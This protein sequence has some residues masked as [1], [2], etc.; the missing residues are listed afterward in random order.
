MYAACSEGLLAHSSAVVSQTEE[1][2]APTLRQ[3]ALNVHTLIYTDHH[4]EDR[5]RDG[6]IGIEQQCNTGAGL[7]P[8]RRLGL[9]FLSRRGG[10]GSGGAGADSNVGVRGSCS[11]SGFN[12][13]GCSAEGTCGGA[14]GA[15]CSGDTGR[16]VALGA[17]VVRLIGPLGGGAAQCV[18][19]CTGKLASMGCR[20]SC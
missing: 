1:D 3:A 19:Q 5:G 16:L 10:Y 17:G 15:A 4:G 14:R 6:F 8:C 9:C 13:R 12:V 20:A 7:G 18:R 2:A 11:V